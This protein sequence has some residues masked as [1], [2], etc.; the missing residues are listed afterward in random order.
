MSVTLAWPDGTEIKAADATDALA[1]VGNLQWSPMDVP[2][3][4]ARLSDRA[5]A[6]SKATIDPLLPDDEFLTA[7]DASRL[8]A[9]IYGPEPAKPPAHPKRAT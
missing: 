2:T 7:L 1:R 5:W 4:K 9:V 6:W 3:I 8:C